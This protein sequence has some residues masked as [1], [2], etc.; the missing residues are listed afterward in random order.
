LTEISFSVLDSLIF[1]I[2][3]I[4]VEKN[5]M[6]GTIDKFNIVFPWLRNKYNAINYRSTSMLQN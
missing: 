5:Y 1:R 4:S 3:V 6:H 2:L